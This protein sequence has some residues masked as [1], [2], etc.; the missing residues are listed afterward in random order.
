MKAGQNPAVFSEGN[1]MSESSAPPLTTRDKKAT[2]GRSDISFGCG[3]LAAFVSLLMAFY[4][5]GPAPTGL[6]SA[7]VSV[8]MG[9]MFGGGLF[10][11]TLGIIV[12]T[13]NYY[14][15]N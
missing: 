13:K 12:Y 9:V 8:L 11:L 4:V 5:G 2:V 3:L 6:V 10:A 1:T 15:K 7:F 14:T